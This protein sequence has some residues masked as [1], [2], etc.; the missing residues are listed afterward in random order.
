MKRSW[1]LSIL[2]LLVGAAVAWPGRTIAAAQSAAAADDLNSVLAKMN[3]NAGTFKSAQAD[4]EFETY[5]KVVDEKDLQKGRIYFRRNAKGVDAAFNITSPA[6]KQ[7]VF[8][9]KDGKVDMY[10]PKIDQVTERDVSKNKADVEAFLS[11]GFGARGDDLQKSYDVSLAGWEPVD[12]VRTAKLELIPKNEKMRQTYN[13][14]VVWLDPE[15]DVLL[16]QQFIEPS[17][18]YRLTRYSK[19]KLNGKLP[20]DAFKL[21]TTGN[22]KTV[23]S[24]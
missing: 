21:K 19:M 5:Q 22:T 15:K 11:L 10:E 7:V 2:L 12:A 1:L 8:N 16:K 6:P 24:Q 18:D 20:D 3:A 17:G 14:I 23:K 9:S 13:K 4:F